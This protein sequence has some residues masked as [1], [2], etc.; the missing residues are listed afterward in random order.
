MSDG[1][2]KGSSSEEEKHPV[3]QYQHP[4]MMPYPFYYPPMYPYPAPYPTEKK[5]K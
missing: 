5:K 3:Q 2:S 1:E 4:P